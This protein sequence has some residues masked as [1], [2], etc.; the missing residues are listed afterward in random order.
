MRWFESG[1]LW[2]MELHP[3][4]ITQVWRIFTPG[5]KECFASTPANYINHSDVG[6]M[7]NDPV[8]TLKAVS[9]IML[10]DFSLDNASRGN[11]EVNCNFDTDQM[12]CRNFFIGFRYLFVG[13]F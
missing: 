2:A 4:F 5:A 12:A 9:S 8:V 7:N 11:S 13:H 1:N 3:T 10:N 6:G